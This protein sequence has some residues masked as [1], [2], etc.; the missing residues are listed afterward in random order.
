[1]NVELVNP[2]V[3]GTKQVLSMFTIDSKMGKASVKNKPFEDKINVSINIIGEYT[4][5]VNYAFNKDVALFLASK[6]MYMDIVELDD[7]SKSAIRELCNM[8][9]GTIATLF[10]NNGNIIDIKPPVLEETYGSCEV[11]KFISVPL[12]LDA[13]KLL[14]LNLWLEKA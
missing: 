6:M 12:E 14:E 2:C 8:I 1:M 9:S 11:D 5:T 13:S 3:E 10:S 4:G 7:I